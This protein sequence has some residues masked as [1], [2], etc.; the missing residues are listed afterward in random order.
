MTETPY[1]RRSEIESI[2]EQ[3][4]TLL[5]RVFRYE[6][7]GLTPHQIAAEEGNENPNFVYN[8]R[9][10]LRA[11]LDEEIPTGPSLATQT[12]RRVRKWLKAR[13]ISD[14]LRRS[15]I[16]LEARL[17]HKAEDVSAQLD[18]AAEAAGRSESAEAKG[19]QGVYVY[20]LPHY[21]RHPIDPESGKT[22]LKV[23][24]SSRDAFYR[25]GS[26]GRRTALPEDPILLRIYP[27]DGSAEA[28]KTFHGW[29]RDADH[30]PAR[31]SRGGSEW[32]LTSTR[33]L[34]RVARSL[35]LTVQVVNEFE[36]GDD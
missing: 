32:F 24:H 35:R 28:E 33:F 7:S 10:Q 22:Y 19:A 27:T 13:S 1:D 9:T 26:A 5:G 11:L 17:T 23:G 30:Q 16:D 31:T 14:D 4:Q 21:L 3:D 36:L 12:A 2:L 29:L 34:D 20:T 25:A 15:L 6:R 8:Y 18:E